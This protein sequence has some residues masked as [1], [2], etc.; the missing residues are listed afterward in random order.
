[1]F[2]IEILIVNNQPLYCLRT[3]QGE[4]ILCSFDLS[5][6]TDAAKDYIEKPNKK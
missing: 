1:M 6:I 2:C 3:M 5:K 4:P